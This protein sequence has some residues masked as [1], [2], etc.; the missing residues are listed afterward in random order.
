[1]KDAKQSARPIRE[2]SLAVAPAFLLRLLAILLAVGY[3]AAR[4]AAA[5]E[6]VSTRRPVDLN[7]QVKELKNLKWGMY[8]CWSLTCFSGKYGRRTSRRSRYSTPQ[9]ATRIN[10][11]ARPRMPR[12]VSSAS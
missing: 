12:W 3:I 1:M 9:D 10:G 6:P 5:A 11:L 4:G 2:R 8:L 7:K